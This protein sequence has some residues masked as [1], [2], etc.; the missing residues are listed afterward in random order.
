MIERAKDLHR[1]KEWTPHLAMERRSWKF[2]GAQGGPEAPEG[3]GPCTLDP[4]FSSG[5]V[6]P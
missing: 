5:A 4:E 1:G 3:P 6:V 2:G